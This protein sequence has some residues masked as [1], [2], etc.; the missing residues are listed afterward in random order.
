M[1][2][3]IP[4]VFIQ[5][6]LE[7]TNIITL[8]QSKI[9]LKK[10]GTHYRAL[11]PFHNETIPSFTVN[12]KNQFFYCFGCHVN[13]N[14][15]DFLMTYEKIKFPQAIQILTELHGVKIPKKKNF[16]FYK[17]KIIKIKKI[18]KILNQAARIY[19]NN[20]FYKKNIAYQYLKSR[21]I[22]EETMKKFH[23]GYSTI[24]HNQLYDYFKDKKTDINLLIQA[25][26]VIHNKTT[27]KKYDQFIQRIM[28]PIQDRYGKINGFGGRTIQSNKFPKYLNS[29]E[30]LI[31]HK[32]K[33]LYGIHRIYTIRP[34]PE[35]ILVVEGYLD[36]ISLTQYNINYS[37]AL[38]GTVLTNY[39][40]NILL[41]L[42]KN[43][44]FCYDGDQSGRDAT[45]KTLQK[46][47]PYLHDNYVIKF[48]FLPD[49][50]DPSSIIMKEG[51]KRFEK[52]IN[53]SKNFFSVIFKKLTKNINLN[54]TE[55]CIKLCNLIILIIKKIPG[56]L[57]KL[58]IL[59]ILCEKTGIH[60]INQLY[61]IIN[62]PAII[63]KKYFKK[64]QKIT[65]MR[66]LISLLLQY[67]K[68]ALLIK[69]FKKIK[70]LNITGN[71]FLYNLLKLIHKNPN[72]NTGQ[73]IEYYRF[74]KLN[75]I[76][77]HLSTWDNMI[78]KNN[79]KIIFLE[80]LTRLK[81]INLENKYNIL[82]SK[83]KKDGLD[84]IEKKKIWDINKK[85]AFLKKLDT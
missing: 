65:I 1:K 62:E 10:I 22:Q 44:I 72:F 54:Y 52:R 70:H 26:L 3:K 33:N 27:N 9:E 79:V 42:T 82:I 31:F 50:E 4:N 41:Q 85:L 15:I 56:Q 20:L 67:P 81:K 51:K 71:L 25:G 21:N 64:S 68:L 28:F 57:I 59:K 35:K 32:K 17:K 49:N 34:K 5:N 55:D 40:I 61:K 39:Q 14:A 47:L 23:I 74:S 36:V 80:L 83:E 48:I 63:K 29:P 45:W 43:I 46:F 13:G 18:Y 6:L 19:Q 58:H 84:N 77:K 30:T 38:L 69:N 73:I 12:K 78:D 8:I 16:I 66:L 7:K 75:L 76:F 60:D 53:T 24:Q 11:C 2:E 37:V